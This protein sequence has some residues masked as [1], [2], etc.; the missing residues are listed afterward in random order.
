MTAGGDRRQRL[1]AAFDAVVELDGAE[2]ERELAR[3]LPDDNALRHEV[4]RLLAASRAAGDRFER[5]PGLPDETL[6]E[7]PAASLVGR[8]FGPYRVTRRVGQGGMGAVYEAER[9]DGVVRHRVAI[10]SV[11]RGADSDVLVRRFR[12]ERRILAGLRHPNIAQFLDAGATEEGT[13]YLAMEFVEG[14]PIDAYCDRHRLTLGARLALFLETCAAVQHAHRHLVVH[15]D[16]KPSNVMVTDDGHVK[17]LDFGVAKLLDDPREAGTLTGAGLSPFTAAYAAPEQVTGGGVSTATDVYA[18]GALLTVLLTGRA[19]IDVAHLTPGEL[20]TTIRDRPATPPSDLA[21]NAG[22]TEPAAGASIPAVATG[23]PDATSPA[24]LAGAR[25]F[26]DARQLA[27]ELTG[28]LDAIALMALRKEPARRYATVDALAEDVRRYLRRDRVLARPDTVAYRLQTFVR[29]RRPLVTGVAIAAVALVGA[30]TVS[31]FKA[32][33]SRQAAERSERVARFLGRITTADASTVDPIARLGSRGTVAQLLDSLATRVPNEFPDDVRIRARLYAAIGPNFTAQGR[34]R[35]AELVLDSAVILSRLGYGARSDE[36]VAAVLEKAAALSAR[37]AT[38]ESEQLVRQAL[39]A[40]AGRERARPDL[41]ARVLVGLANILGMV[42]DMRASDS[43]SREAIRIELARTRQPTTTRSLATSTRALAA[44]WLQRDP[45]VVDSIY[46]HAVAI[47]DSLHT[48]LAFE[49]LRAI[50]GRIDALTPLGRFDLAERLLREALASA[51]QGYGPQS[52]EAALFLARTSNL[53]RAMGDHR[54]AATF[55]DS[56]WNVTERMPDF[57]A[58]LVVQV[59]TARIQSAW[60]QGQL[61][62]ADSIA[63]VV[64]SRVRAQNAPSATINAALYAGLAA[65]QVKDWPRAESGLRDALALLPPTGDMNSMVDRVR[66]PLAQVLAA[67]GRQR[68]ADSLMA[69]VP[70]Q[71]PVAR[72]RPGGDWRGC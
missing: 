8:T 35:E 61:V 69:L 10:K 40:L 12:S 2:Q 70:S 1:R 3:L 39:A 71:V 64:L 67:Q 34:I 6:D 59:G 32:R 28:E 72:C 17:L 50:D 29:R 44:A 58:W 22:G 4:G 57:T 51:E 5:A 65:A 42:G 30:T 37:T 60:Q 33:E 47:T 38:V 24:T 25:G 45:R 15:R 27:R 18:L 41:H 26:A 62:L 20:L 13:P 54:R 23:G 11:W 66:G 16:L 53:A 52:R 55:A 14:A 31:V 56:A 48:P 36:Y 49:R 7:A 43:L 21:R 9:V 19:P 63:R 68:E 46:A